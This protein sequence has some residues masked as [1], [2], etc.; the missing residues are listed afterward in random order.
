MKS[1]ILTPENIA[2]YTE[3]HVMSALTITDSSFDQEVLK[4]D[5]PV[6]I[7]FWAA[8]CQPCRMVSP[9]IDE[10]AKEY[11]G[12]VKVGKVNVDENNQIA[13]QYGVM[14]IPSVMVFKNGAPS[15]TLV[16]VQSK[17]TYKNAIDGAL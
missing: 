15:K 4:S 16:G 13:S 5:L 6:V 14:S 3:S 11:E 17:D 12:K 1:H 2:R 8:W 10:L 7:D 9:V